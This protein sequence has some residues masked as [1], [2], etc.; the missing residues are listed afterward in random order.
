MEKKCDPTY[1]RVDELLSLLT[2]SKSLHTLMVL[3]RKNAPV[4]FSELKNSVDSSSTTI[5]RRLNELE[6]HGLVSRT[7]L[8]NSNH[9]FE[10]SMTEDAKTL[11]PIMQSLFEW[12]DG[13]TTLST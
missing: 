2:K 10:Y 5:A 6:E 4:R 1:G 7:P 12:V 11:S 8:T 13:R 9:G 3:D